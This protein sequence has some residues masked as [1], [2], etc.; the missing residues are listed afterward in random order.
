MNPGL[1]NAFEPAVPL[2]T[3]IKRVTRT[4]NTGALGPSDKS[5]YIDITSGTFTQTFDDAART[6]DGWFVRL[7]NSGTGD[8]TIPSSDGVTNWPMMPGE[9][10][11]FYSNGSAYFSVIVKPFEKIFTASGTFTKPP[12][13]KVFWGEIWNGG[14]SGSKGLTGGLCN[15]GGGGGG[16]FPFVLPTSSFGT[17]ETIT[18]GAGGVAVS[19]ANT[20]GNVGGVSSIGTLLVMGTMGSYY[21][22]SCI[23]TGAG[24]NAQGVGFEIGTATAVTPG[25]AI[26]GGASSR[27]GGATAQSGNSVYGGATGGGIDADNV[28]L[29]SPGTSK[30]GGNGSA[31]SVAGVATAGSTPGGGGGATVSGTSGAGGRGELRIRGA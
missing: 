10:R 22:G 13:Y 8:I 25:H 21:Q 3:T 16:G 18:I 5:T 11:D 29:A 4:S 27:N 24:S 17:T 19:V 1:F 12:G 7:G 26:W 15:P 2:S 14:G 20:A 30:F 9:V 31:A 28:T 6:A 23:T